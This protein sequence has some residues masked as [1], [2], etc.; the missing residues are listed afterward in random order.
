MQQQYS[1]SSTTLA[2]FKAIAFVPV[3]TVYV[4]GSYTAGDQTTTT[5]SRPMQQSSTHRWILKQ[6]LDAFSS[7]KSTSSYISLERYVP[8]FRLATPTGYQINPIPKGDL[9]CIRIQN[10]YWYFFAAC[11]SPAGEGVFS[12]FRLR[13]KLCVHRHYTTHVSI[14]AELHGGVPSIQ[15]G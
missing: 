14:L 8:P 10:K 13:S 5:F 12:R 11:C 1:S 3:V 6:L 7:S 2:V 4:C 15:R 9:A